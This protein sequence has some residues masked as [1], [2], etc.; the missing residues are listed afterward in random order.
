MQHP[1]VGIAFGSYW[2]PRVLVADGA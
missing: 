1:A 2:S